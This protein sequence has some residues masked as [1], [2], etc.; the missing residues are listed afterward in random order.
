MATRWL[1][2][3]EMRLWRAFIQAGPSVIGRIDADLRADAD[4]TMDDYEVLV[5]LSEIPDHRLR[6][7]DL[8]E[9]VLQSRARLSQR[10]DRMAARGLVAREK[11]DADGRGTFAALTPHGRAT[12]N[13][14]APDHVASVRRH[15]LDALDADAV[16]GTADALWQI[17]DGLED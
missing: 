12:I 14:A 16:A 2:D 8:S 1:N 10:I 5:H 3:D 9:R 6:M 7:S 15:L 13:S 11:C 4:L 17:L